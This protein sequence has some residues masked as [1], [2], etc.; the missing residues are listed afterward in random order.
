MRCAIRMKEVAGGGWTDNPFLVETMCLANGVIYLDS[1]VY[2]YRASTDDLIAL[3]GNWHIPYDR[4]MEIHDW[5]NRHSIVDVG[6]LCERYRMHLSYLFTMSRFATSQNKR[7]LSIAISNCARSFSDVAVYGADVMSI[8]E[9]L[10]IFDYRYLTRFRMYRNIHPLFNRIW[11][12]F[13]RC[14]G[15]LLIALYSRKLKI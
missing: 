12:L 4:M 9:K 15:R 14:Y 10:I 3:K 1:A 11:R 6:V 13:E 8:I 5:F 2:N 7:E